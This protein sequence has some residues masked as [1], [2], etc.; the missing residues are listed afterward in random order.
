MCILFCCGGIS[1]H[2]HSRRRVG[3]L[4]IRISRSITVLSRK[5]DHLVI[6]RPS[7]LII[8]IIFE[9]SIFQC[10]LHDFHGR[11]KLPSL[12]EEL[13]R[14]ALLDSGPGAPFDNCSPSGKQGVPPYH[15]V[16]LGSAQL[17]K[18]LPGC[19]Y[20]ST[21]DDAKINACKSKFVWINSLGSARYSVATPHRRSVAQN[22]IF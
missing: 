4:T 21:S 5:D 2:D 6:F 20:T 18:T 11:K 9:M 15:S 8:L 10:V 14:E 3:T 7:I 22:R 16:Q 1:A 19:P 17:R 13:G 12:G